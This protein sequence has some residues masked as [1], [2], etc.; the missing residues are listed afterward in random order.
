MNKLRSGDLRR[1]HWG[2]TIIP[3]DGGT[4]PGLVDAVLDCR[5]YTKASAK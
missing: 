1:L 4:S 5:W 3:F 2:D